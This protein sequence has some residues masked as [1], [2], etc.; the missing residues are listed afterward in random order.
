MIKES[1]FEEEN[2]NAKLSLKFGIYV[3]FLL[4]PVLCLSL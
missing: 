2:V 1:R 4:Y 3:S